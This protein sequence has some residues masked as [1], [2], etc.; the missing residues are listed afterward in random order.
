MFPRQWS[1]HDFRFDFQ[2]D[3]AKDELTFEKGDFITV[4]GKAG[5]DGWWV[6]SKER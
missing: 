1:S 4:F 3:A 2:G 6:S 5:S